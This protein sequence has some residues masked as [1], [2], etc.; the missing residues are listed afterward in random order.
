MF[1]MVAKNIVQEINNEIHASRKR[2]CKEE[3][4]EIKRDP[5]SM[6]AK[7]YKSER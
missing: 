3:D 1:N 2:K 5:T 6:K 4:E 7:K